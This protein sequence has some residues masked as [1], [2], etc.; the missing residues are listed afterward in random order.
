M[1][2]TYAPTFWDV[3]WWIIFFAWIM[4]VRLVMVV[5]MDNFR[6]TDSQDGQKQCGRCSSSSCR[7][8]ASSST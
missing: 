2:A 6:R 4:F 1:P 8:S 3:V 5:F 7:S